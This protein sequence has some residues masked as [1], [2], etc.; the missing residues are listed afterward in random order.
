M[1]T[2]GQTRDNENCPIEIG[3]GMEI[4]QDQIDDIE[5]LQSPPNS[6]GLVLPV[7]VPT[8]NEKIDFFALD[9]TLHKEQENENSK[10]ED[11]NPK[12]PVTP[13]A[14]N[15][16]KESLDLSIFRS[17]D[18]YF[19][20]SRSHSSKPTPRLRRTS[21]VSNRSEGYESYASGASYDSGSVFSE[22]DTDITASPT[23]KYSKKL[24][25]QRL[26]NGMNIGELQNGK[27][28]EDGIV[29]KTKSSGFSS[30][31][32]SQYT[33]VSRNR[34]RSGSRSDSR[35][36]GGM[37]SESKDKKN[38]DTTSQIFKNLLILEESLRQQYIEQQNL[39]LK[40]SIFVVILVVAFS[41][42]TYHG[43]F[44]SI[45][46][47]HE[48]TTNWPTGFGTNDGDTSV[49]VL[50]TPSPCDASFVCV[51]FPKFPTQLNGEEEGNHG[52]GSTTTICNTK[53]DSTS[54]SP[55][56]NEESSEGYVLINIVYRV[57]S[58]ITGM[59]LLLFYLTGE[60]THK[61]SRPRKFFV[62]ANK[63]IRQLNVRLVK[64]KVPFKERVLNY[65]RLRV[66]KN[67]R[68][69]VDHIRLVLNPR[70]FSTANRE[71]WELYRNQFW[72]LEK[73]KHTSIS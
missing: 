58:I 12:L 48:N 38:D 55:M 8:T 59:T 33:P 65:L 36:R 44:N 16:S 66:K 35:D 1:D 73:R 3:M 50:P 4:G 13:V 71:Q 61:I 42:S 20:R 67:P 63:G 39:R 40:Y 2:R 19:S 5:D 57:V 37:R 46:V 31:T 51:G 21:D 60:Y 70:V 47:Q 24:R 30:D 72:N 10:N 23:L 17:S 27:S 25:N 34:S 7:M 68:K 69:G 41:L 52:L 43:I 45:Y 14:Q 28:V 9:G 6:P 18:S 32:G 53:L 49:S 15:K 29:Y 22:S 26:D 11:P 54:I 64:V 62:T 56:D